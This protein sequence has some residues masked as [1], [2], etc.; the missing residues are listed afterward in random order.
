M[1]FFLAYFHS[2]CLILFNMFKQKSLHIVAICECFLRRMKDRY[3]LPHISSVDR[4][5]LHS[6]RV[7]SEILLA[8]MYENV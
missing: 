2:V 1:T 7:D 4:M 3:I 8:Q 6:L 5:F